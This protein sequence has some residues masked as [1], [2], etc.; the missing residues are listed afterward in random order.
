MTTS[1]NLELTKEEIHL[2]IGLL[3][4]MHQ[5]AAPIARELLAKLKRL[6]EGK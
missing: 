3:V 2:L 5:P 6:A 1:Y 4:G